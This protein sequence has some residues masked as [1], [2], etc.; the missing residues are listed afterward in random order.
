MLPNLVDQDSA[1]ALKVEDSGDESDESCDDE[2]DCTGSS[3]S[4]PDF[5]KVKA[6]APL[7]PPPSRERKTSSRLPNALIIAS[8]STIGAGQPDFVDLSPKQQI[9]DLVKLAQEV[10][11]LDPD[12]IA[13]E[14]TRVEVKL[15]LEIQVCPARP[16]SILTIAHGLVRVA[17]ALAPLHS[18]L[19]EKRLRNRAHLGLQCGFESSCKLASLFGLSLHLSLIL[20]LGLFLSS[21]VMTDPGPAPSR[22]RNLL[23][24]LRSFVR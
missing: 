5:V 17:K 16:P 7:S 23:R 18:R 2:A 20:F 15:F 1:W 22:S 13:Q 4:T 10:L 3:S 12:E 14:I 21:C 24:L 9:K 6:I 19:W 11:T 8:G